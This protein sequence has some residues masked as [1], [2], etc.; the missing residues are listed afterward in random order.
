MKHINTFEVVRTSSKSKE[1]WL[2]PTDERYKEA[3]DIINCTD[4][5]YISRIFSGSNEYED[6]DPI[7]LKLDTMG[8]GWNAFRGD[9]YDV[10]FDILGYVNNGIILLTDED[11]WLWN[12]KQNVKKYNI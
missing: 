9:K 6:D 10:Y 3:L 5:N 1:Y 12:L 8:W 7:F 4:S 2:I 11:F